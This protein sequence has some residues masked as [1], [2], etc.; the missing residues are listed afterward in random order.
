[1]KLLS[2]KRVALV[3]SALFIVI[4]LLVG[5]WLVDSL[6]PMPE[7]LFAMESDDDEF[8]EPMIVTVK[9][10]KELL[11]SNKIT[12]VKTI[13]ALQYYFLEVHNE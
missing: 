4:I 6:G 10:A 3:S 2:K 5:L 13:L 8:I 1:M 11:K 7:A 9:E 12:D